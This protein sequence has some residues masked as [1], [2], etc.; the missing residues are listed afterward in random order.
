MDPVVALTD[1]EAESDQ[2]AAKRF[3]GKATGRH[4]PKNRRLPDPDS[5]AT[6]AAAQDLTQ[7]QRD[8]LFAA[9]QSHFG[10]AQPV[11]RS[12]LQEWQPKITEHNSSQI[13]MRNN[14]L[15]S[16]QMALQMQEASAKRQQK[17][18]DAVKR[19]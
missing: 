8:T 2:P 19:P 15:A 10:R 14:I 5:I 13:L 11:T 16:N 4:Q 17:L 12:M 9:A 1:I 18:L 3:K 6:L 7:E